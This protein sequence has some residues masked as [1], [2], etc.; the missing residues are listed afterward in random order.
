VGGILKFHVSS[1]DFVEE[2]QPIATNIDVVDA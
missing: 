2:G 1:G